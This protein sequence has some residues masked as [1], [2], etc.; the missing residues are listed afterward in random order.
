MQLKDFLNIIG[1]G[2]QI[3]IY[4][5]KDGKTLE[6]CESVLLYCGRVE[7]VERSRWFQDYEDDEVDH[8]FT[9]NSKTGL[10]IYIKNNT[11]YIYVVD[12]CWLT[13]EDDLISYENDYE[14]FETEE[15]ALKYAK[16]YA[17]LLDDNERYSVERHIV[18]SDGTI[19]C[20]EGIDLI[21]NKDGK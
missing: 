16:E 15:E 4:A 11:H 17:F 18:Y 3:Y 20:D 5:K 8:I 7:Q 6:E 21:S 12:K 1:S 10:D 9:D 19:E 2:T 13:S 14:K